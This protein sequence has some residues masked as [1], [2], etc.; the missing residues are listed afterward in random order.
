MTKLPNTVIAQRSYT[1]VDDEF[2]KQALS[3]NGPIMVA[4]TSGFSAFSSYS[5]GIFDGCKN[6]NGYVDHAV[7]L[8]GFTSEGH[9][10]IKNSWG[11]DW[12]ENGYMTID[13]N[14]NCQITSYPEYIEV[15]FTE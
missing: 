12:G 2:L 9:W 14:H 10:I 15:E 4:I 7:L 3:S 1:S 5:S 6:Y 8:V 11:S 13:K